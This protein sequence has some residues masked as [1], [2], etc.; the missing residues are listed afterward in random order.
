MQLEYGKTDCLQF[1]AD[2]VKAITGTDHLDKFPVYDSQLAAAKILVEAGGLRPLISSV[3]G[4]EKPAAWAKRGDVVVCVDS[5][6]D[7]HAGICLGPVW[8]GPTEAGLIFPPM[9]KAI[10]A[11]TV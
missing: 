3:L 11:W 8:A 9:T 7:Q 5:N 4:D 10:A 2:V 1:C 6:G